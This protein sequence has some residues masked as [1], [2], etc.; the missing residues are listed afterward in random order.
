MNE[1]LS[2]TTPCFITLIGLLL[3]TIG[4]IAAFVALVEFYCYYLFTEGGRFHYDGFGFG[5]FM[6]GNITMQIWGYYIIAL[7]CIPLGYGHLKK[8]IWIQKITLAFL[9]VWFI[10][11]ISILPIIFFIFVTS[12]KPSLL[13]IILCTILCL[14]SYT[15]IPAI[16]IKFL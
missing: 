15:L 14:L 8:Q 1:Y 3:L 9:W 2:K 16:L 4:I 10:V 12:K 11:G 7:I 6:F 13:F 5:S